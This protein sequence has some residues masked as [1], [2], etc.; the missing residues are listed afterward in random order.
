MN[1]KTQEGVNKSFAA[2]V[3]S[4]VTG[5]VAPPQKKKETKCALWRAKYQS[6]MAAGNTT[7]AAKW[8]PSKR[9]SRC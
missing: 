9:R 1:R 7:E 5:P 6:L 3:N 2:N 4:P 8:N